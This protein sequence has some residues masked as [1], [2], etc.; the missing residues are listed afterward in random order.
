MKIKNIP[1]DMATE[2]MANTPD[3]GERYWFPMRVSYGR[4]AAVANQLEIHHKEIE[5]YLPTEERIIYRNEGREHYICREQGEK[6]GLK[7]II[8]S[9]DYLHSTIVTNDFNSCI[10]EFPLTTSLIFLH[11]TRTQIRKLKQSAEPLSYLRFITFIQQA[12]IHNNM[13]TEELWAARNICVIPKKQIEDFMRLVESAKNHITLI[14][15]DSFSNY[16]GKKIRFIEGPL[17][18]QEATIRRIGKEKNKKFFFEL[19]GLIVARVEYIP[20]QQYE[21]VT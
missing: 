6:N 12:D 13:S 18:G 8:N 19:Q 5:Y 10:V 15:Y 9:Q 20:K 3:N 14:P 16:V 21:I 2:I 11:G 17:K 1:P 7:I 4:A